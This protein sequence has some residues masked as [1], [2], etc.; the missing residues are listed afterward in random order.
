MATTGRRGLAMESR[1][2]ARVL[3]LVLAWAAADMAGGAG[4]AGEHRRLSTQA[5]SPDKSRASMHIAMVQH[6]TVYHTVL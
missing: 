6:A 2:L 4:E 5:A 1:G 3:F